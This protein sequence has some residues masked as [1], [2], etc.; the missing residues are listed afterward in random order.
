M[1]DSLITKKAIAASFKEL[2]REKG[3]GKVSVG[4]VTAACGLNRQTFYYHFEDKYE[5]LDWVYYHDIFAGLVTG[6]TL[7]NWPQ[8]LAALLRGMQA[9]KKFYA[10]TVKAQPEH[11]FQYLF[12]IVHPLFEEAIQQLNGPDGP[13]Q[14]TASFYADF[15]THGCCG[16][17]LTWAA[18]GMQASGDEIAARLARLSDDAQ[19]LSCR[20]QA[21]QKALPSKP[22]F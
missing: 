8:H 19:Q 22:L 14:E 6:I 15:F 20:L 17:I 21:K 13:D 16:V 2:C 4:D 7:D 10:G 18:G 12:R 11:F 1:P 3:F 5:L 9:D